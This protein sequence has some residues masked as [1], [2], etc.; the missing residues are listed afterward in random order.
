MFISL[1]FAR[2]SGGKFKKTSWGN[3]ALIGVIGGGFAGLTTAAYLVKNN[4][5]A[6]LLEASPKIGGRAYSFKDKEKNTT[7]DNG[8][9]ILMGCYFETLKFLDLIGATNNFYFQKKLE[10]NFVKENFDLQPLK[11]LS[12]FYPINLLIGL[13][14]FKAISRATSTCCF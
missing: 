10:V 4:Y 8:Q 3:L 7:L 12:G 6:I 11:T 5:R 14:N 1:Y 2:K 13:L 9:H